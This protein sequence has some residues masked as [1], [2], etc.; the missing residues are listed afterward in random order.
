MRQNTRVCVCMCERELE[1]KERKERAGSCRPRCPTSKWFVGRQKLSCKRSRH[2]R[3]VGDQ[4]SKAQGSPRG[5][6]P[7]EPWGGP[8]K[9]T[10][11]PTAVGR[12]GLWFAF[13]E[14]PTLPSEGGELSLL[15]SGQGAESGLLSTRPLVPTPSHRPISS[16][17]PHSFFLS[18]FQFGL[19]TQLQAHPRAHHGAEG[20][21][22]GRSGA[23]G[24]IVPR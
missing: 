24:G 10:L 17:Q 22:R 13:P 14:T 4:P 21:G 6:Q 2:P 8:Q 1:G 7:P 18:S 23:P 15:S 9:A 5:L 11:S 3:R 20:G 16:P 19:K 12:S